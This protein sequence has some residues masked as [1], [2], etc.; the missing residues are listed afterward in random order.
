MLLTLHIRQKDN[1][2]IKTLPLALL[3]MERFGSRLKKAKGKV[4]NSLWD[5]LLCKLQEC[6]FQNKQ[7]SKDDHAC[8]EILDLATQYMNENPRDKSH[9]D[10]ITD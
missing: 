2:I 8:V 9:Q 7:Y 5:V 10:T 1:R 4:D 3:S 6:V